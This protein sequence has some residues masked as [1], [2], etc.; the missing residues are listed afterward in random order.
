[1][2]VKTVNQNGN[3][4]I[5]SK[6]VLGEGKI[7]VR[8]ITNATEKKFGL[9]LQDLTDEYKMGDPLSD[10]DKKAVFENGNTILVFSTLEGLDNFISTLKSYRKLIGREVNNTN[11][12][13]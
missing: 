11:V 3:I 5:I 12:V 4:V 7:A 10:S 2:F 8:Y 13:T 6:C 1:V 9:W